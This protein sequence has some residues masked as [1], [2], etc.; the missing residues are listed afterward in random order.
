[1]V[2]A[3]IPAYAAKVATI[4]IE[5]P[6]IQV[7]QAYPG[8]SEGTNLAFMGYKG[9]DGDVISSVPGI[10]AI[11]PGT[12]WANFVGAANA[13]PPVSYTIKNTTL[14]KRTPQIVQC[15]D[16]FTP[17]TVAQQ[18][19]PNIRTWWPLMYEVPSTTFTLII[20]YG[21]PVLWDDDGPSGPNPPSYVHT[22]VW[23]WHVDADLFSMSYLLELF[24]ELPFG[25]DEV[26]LVS[27]ESLYPILQLK[28]AYI[29]YFLTQGDLVSAGLLLGDFEM[30]VMDACISVSP[31]YPNPTGPGTGIAM[32]LENPACCKLLADSEYVGKKYK[33]LQ[34]T[35]P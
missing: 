27:D 26:P 8:N 17:K 28:L 2:I 20:L 31:L 21:T 32:T 34:P 5:H 13:D 25:L 35:A 11:V 16:V 19:T 23:T 9:V 4:P 30:E 14:I 6:P 33:I 29:W 3:A 18:G 10:L 15:A 7:Y 1:M 24:H 12:N 22:E